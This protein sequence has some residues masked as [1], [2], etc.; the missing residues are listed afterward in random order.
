MIATPPEANRW[1][2]LLL[3]GPSGAGK[4]VFAGTAQDDP[5]TSPTLVLDLEGG[6]DSLVGRAI[7]TVRIKSWDDYAAA[8]KL[9]EQGTYR[10]VVL[11]S[12]SELQLYALNTILEKE[13][14]NRR[15]K[16]L[17]D[18][19]DYGRGLVQMR[20]FVRTW[21]DVDLHVVMTALSKEILDPREGTVLVPKFSGQFGEDA[22]AMM[23]VVA[24]LAITADAQTNKNRRVLLLKNQS[25]FRVKAR[26]PWGADVPDTISEPTITKLLDCLGFPRDE[27]AA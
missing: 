2:K 16:D 3:F 11:D 18:Q 23:S 5:R 24:Y 25:K 22:S 26:T 27:K 9:I 20:R 17:L 15:E 1:L 13:A 7:D 14:A 6:I 21:R 4:T 12:L 8:A 10:S 19:R